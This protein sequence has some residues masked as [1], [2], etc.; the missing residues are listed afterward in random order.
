M[1]H[2]R[3][4]LVGALSMLVLS[5][6]C[7]LL[8]A[9]P[10][11]PSSTLLV[12]KTE[13]FD[14]F[15]WFGESAWTTF[16]TWGPGRLGKDNVECSTHPELTERRA[17]GEYCSDVY[18]S[19]M[20]ST[21]VAIRTLTIGA[22]VL[23]C[24]GMLFALQ[25]YLTPTLERKVRPSARAGAAVALSWAVTLGLLLC[26][27]LSPFFT[28]DHFLHLGHG[29]IINYRGLGCVFQTPFTRGIKGVLSNHPLK[30]L[31]PGPVVPL[32]S[33]SALMQLFSFLMFG[34]LTRDTARLVLNGRRSLAAY[35]WA[36]S[37]P[38]LDPL[39]GDGNDQP[40][41]ALRAASDPATLDEAL[42]LTYEDL[43]YSLHGAFMRRL[44]DLH[45]MEQRVVALLV[46]ACAIGNG[47]LFVSWFYHGIQ[48]LVH[49]HAFDANLGGG[50]PFGVTFVQITEMVFTFDPITTLKD[51]VRSPRRACAHLRG[52]R[53]NSHASAHTPSA[54]PSGSLVAT[55]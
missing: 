27:F 2:S 52:G 39:L 20:C 54:H 45:P 7:M 21:V 31:Y 51:F 40:Q 4:L 25:T 16:L 35:V 26:I 11:S 33:A 47:I 37:S 8:T 1:Q 55:C 38:A 5:F 42:Q 12:E 50:K 46:P 34:L 29:N 23:Q 44:G 28:Y 41:R 9:V 30:C 36:A 32:L 10:N 48:Y 49:V 13:V 24:V 6:V 17:V 15:C 22:L 3:G 18:G 43:S 14:N 53:T 19:S